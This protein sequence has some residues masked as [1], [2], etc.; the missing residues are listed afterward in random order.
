MSIVSPAIR[1]CLACHGPS[2][3]GD[4]A[5]A[6]V[7]RVVSPASHGEFSAAGGKSV[8]QKWG[9]VGE[10]YHILSSDDSIIAIITDMAPELVI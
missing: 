7:D 3:L 4:P 1:R 8:S 2:M 5:I 10:N 9:F 6:E